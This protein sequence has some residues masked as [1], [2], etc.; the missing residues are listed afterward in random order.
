MNI[1]KL[2]LKQVNDILSW[3]DKNK[4]LV[5][6]YMPYLTEGS[7]QIDDNNRID[8]TVAFGEPIQ[9]TTIYYN[10]NIIV[11]SLTWSADELKGFWLLEKENYVNY[12]LLQGQNEYTY[13]ELR[14]NILTVYASVNAYFFHYRQDLSIVEQKEVNRHTIKGKNNTYKYKIEKSLNKIYTIVGKIHHNKIPG[15][16]QW[17]VDCWG[18]VGHIRHYKNGKEV[19][20]KPYLKGKNRLNGDNNKIYK[21]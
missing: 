4:D 13:E 10:N 18:V 6:R 12:A 20:I 19:Y 5:R 17:R 2:T 15:N 14:Q 9:F 11:F 7:I 21:I 1:I 8:F 3:R 16:R